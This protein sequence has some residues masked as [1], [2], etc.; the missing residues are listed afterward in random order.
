MDNLIRYC[1]DSR[2]LTWYICKDCGNKERTKW[3]YCPVCKN[4]HPQSNP[5]LKAILDVIALKGGI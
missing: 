1:T 4:E 3:R 2:G 5:D